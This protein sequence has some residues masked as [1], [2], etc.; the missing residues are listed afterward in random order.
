MSVAVMITC[1]TSNEMDPDVGTTGDERIK[2]K[3]INMEGSAGLEHG[4]HQDLA[5]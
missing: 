1:R 3:K 5:W 2:T 4:L